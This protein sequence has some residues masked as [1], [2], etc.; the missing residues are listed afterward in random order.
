MDSSYLTGPHCDLEWGRRGAGRAAERGDILVICDVLSFS[1]TCV[2]ANQRGARIYPC[3]DGKEAL[4]CAA[5]FGAEIAVRREE[6]SADH[7]FSLSPNSM[8]AAGPL[9]RIALPSPNGATC[10]RIG[11]AVPALI[12]ASH[13]NASASARAA[14]ALSAEFK[15]NITV[16]SCGERWIQPNEEGQL[17]F[18]LEDYLGAGAVLSGL[19]MAFSPGASVCRSA[20]SA[21]Q[22]DIHN[23][24][25]NCESG[26]ELRDRGWPEDVEHAVQL[27]TCDVVPLLIDG[28]LVGRRF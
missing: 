22:A 18:A 15:A 7:R 8:L 13:L 24:I 20:F 10:C 5:Q 17:R 16:V 28:C 11:A 14:A 9:D 21:S 2:V 1:T 26:I 4:R 27:V 3:I 19:D 6:T 12:V 23:I 25:A